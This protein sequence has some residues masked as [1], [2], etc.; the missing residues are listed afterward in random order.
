MIVEFSAPKGME[1]L[2]PVLND[3][4]RAHL[5][6]QELKYSAGRACFCPHCNNIADFRRWVIAESPNGNLW[7]G[8]TICFQKS[9]DLIHSDNP[10]QHM[11]D[12]GWQINTLVNFNKPKPKAKK[13]PKLPDSVMVLSF[14]KTSRYSVPAVFAFEWEGHRFFAHPSEQHTGYWTVTHDGAGAAVCPVKKYRS[15]KSAIAHSQNALAECGI[16]KFNQLVKQYL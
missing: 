10:F 7:Q 9:L 4:M 14:N 2:A 3:A 11:I 5:Q 16:D 8:C 1:K 15:K 12:S 6:K 13:P